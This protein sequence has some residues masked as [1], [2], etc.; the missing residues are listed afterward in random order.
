MSKELTAEEK[1]AKA[2][3]HDILIKHVFDNL[4]NLFVCAML[5]LSGGA[6][7]KYRVE[8][9]LGSSFNWGIGLLVVVAAVGLFG[10]NMLHGIEKLIRPVK[11]TRK[12]WLL[13]PFAVVYMFA[14]ISIFQAWVIVQA[15]QQLRRVSTQSTPNISVERDASPKSGSRPS[16]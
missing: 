2:D 15:E 9:P 3:A 11:G 6:V 13:V 4:R 5:A 16:P 12:I 8:L 7:L 1:K 14:V 10:W